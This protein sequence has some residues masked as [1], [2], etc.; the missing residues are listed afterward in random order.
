M[1]TT[2]TRAPSATV[3]SANAR[4]VPQNPVGNSGLHWAAWHGRLGMLKV[5]LDAHADPNVQNNGG[6]TALHLVRGERL[7]GNH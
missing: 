4:P 7:R 6:N 1:A 2:V 3:F 5:M